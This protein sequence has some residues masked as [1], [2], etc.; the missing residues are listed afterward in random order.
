MLNISQ[1]LI[2]IKNDLLA[3]SWVSLSGS[4]LTQF[5][6]GYTS[7][8]YSN[9]AG[10]PFFCISDPTSQSQ[11]GTNM[12]E[13]FIHIFK[14]HCCV[15]WEVSQPNAI[16]NQD[17]LETQKEEG[18][19]RIREIW[20]N[21]KPYVVKNTTMD[22]WFGNRTYFMQDFSFAENDID[23]LKVLRRTITI[24]MLDVVSKV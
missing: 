23:V 16:N 15:K 2:N 24:K 19:L 1:S 8:N 13:D 18:M 22:K 4:G 17:F 9:A 6:A 5:Q 10:S 7:E 3:Q 20:D 12:A 21:L 11:M 14:I